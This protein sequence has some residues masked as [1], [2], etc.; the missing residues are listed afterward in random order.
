MNPEIELTTAAAPYPQTE[1]FPQCVR[2]AADVDGITLLEAS[3]KFGFEH[4]CLRLELDGKVQVVDQ[5]KILDPAEPWSLMAS[6]APGVSVHLL[7][8]PLDRSNQY[9][10][11][12][13]VS[14]ERDVPVHLQAAAFGQFG[15]AA[16][17]HPGNG[18]V[19]GWGLRYA[20]T[21]NLRTER[22]PYCAADYPYARQLPI[23]TRFLGD[24]EDEPFPAV[25]IYNEITKWGLV[26]G[27]ATQK[28]A[29]PVFVLQRK[30][31]FRPDAFDIFELRWD[32]PQSTGPL[33]SAGETLE[34]ETIYLQL[35][36]GRLSDYAFEDFLDYLK[37]EHTFR[38]ADTPVN[39]LAVHCTWNYG[40]FDDQREAS[41]MKTAQF[42]SKELPGVGYFLVDDGYLTHHPDQHSRVFLNRFYPDPESEVESKSW[43]DGMRGFTDKLRSMG[44]R[45]G[46]W[47]TPT[48]RL[49]CQLHDDHPDWFLR[50]KDGSIHVIG[51]K[52][53]FL[54]YSNPEALAFLDRTLAVVLGKWGMEACKI[55]FWSQN[56][57]SRRGLLQNPHATS[58]ETRR[59]FFET[60]RRHMPKDGVIVSCI[61]MG[62]GNPFLG[63]FIDTY[64]CSM[65]ISDGLWEDQVNNCLWTLPLLGFG[66]RRS[67]LL[68]SD[69]VGINPRLPDN[70]NFFRLAWIYI[71]MGIIETGGRLEE[72]APR[73]FRAMKKIVDRGDRGYPCRCPEED[74]YTGVPLPGVLF[75]TFPAQS[76]TVRSGIR[77]SVA[78]FNW[79]D[80]P[81]AI[82]VER[83]RLGQPKQARAEDF[84]SGEEE[85]WTQPFLTV[86]LPPRS[87]R[88]FD[89]RW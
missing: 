13:S 32:F 45:A 10:L 55:D 73:F 79:S 41:L 23:E 66:G 44:L 38:G 83:N 62:M 70:E 25:F 27:M 72:L 1:E 78:F 82:S 76:P 53:A 19:L 67:A 85:S 17:F 59:N 30:P 18:H 88:L 64:R 37:S 61:A 54:D 40:V 31:L 6:P 28:S 81:K 57:E 34:L 8:C 42:I 80:Q 21:G 60:V 58:I 39:N 69:S 7:L 11:K 47:W 49:P 22:Y 86:E 12:I 89:V 26:L 46:L 29:V 52:D 36:E 74:V 84:W 87:A 15:E 48:V 50:E 9:A 77:Q 16:L 56:F 24:T 3:K 68:N 43:P 33:I 65:D 51:E 71:T 75:V 14:N 35:T 20:H 2:A 5:F 63:E 4:Y